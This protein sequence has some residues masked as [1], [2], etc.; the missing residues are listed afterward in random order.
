MYFCRELGV[1][2]IFDTQPLAYPHDQ[3]AQH[4]HILDWERFC[5]RFKVVLWNIVTPFSR[6]LVF[7]TCVHPGLIRRAPRDLPHVSGASL[8]L[9]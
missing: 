1:G 9:P 6:L 3:R 2:D 5:D 7:S 4:V 8:L